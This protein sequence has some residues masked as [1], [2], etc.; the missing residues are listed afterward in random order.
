MS[1]RAIGVARHIVTVGLAVFVVTAVVAAPPRAVDRAEA[2]GAAVRC[3]VCQGESIAAS[4]AP[5]AEDMMALVR[6]R[7]DEGLSDEQIIE[8]L[9]ASYSG[10]QLLDPSFGPRTAA[11]WA[12]PTIV[13]LLGIAG[14]AG[15][16]RRT[17]SPPAAAHE[18][19]G[20]HP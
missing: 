4:P 8:E 18:P 2:I 16:V 6:T 15:R 7:I 13:A 14:V 19:T 20:E 5:L 1:D 3:P 10:A 12:I 17:D 11:L 9:L